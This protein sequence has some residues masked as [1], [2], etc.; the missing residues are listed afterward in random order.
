[1]TKIDDQ[2]NFQT[3]SINDQESQSNQNH[4]FF[5]QHRNRSTTVVDQGQTRSRILKK[6]NEK[7]FSKQGEDRKFTNNQRINSLSI[8]K[9]RL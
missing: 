3:I 9:K 6:L 4:D 1:M 2:T 5:N 7:R 8:K